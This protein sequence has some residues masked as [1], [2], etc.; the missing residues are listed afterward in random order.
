MKETELALLVDSLRGVAD[1]ATG[2]A[3]RRRLDSDPRLRSTLQGFAAVQ[4][5]L[6]AASPPDSALA[7]ARALGSQRRQ[8]PETTTRLRL[9]ALEP[10]LEGLAALKPAGSRDG[11][12]TL[13]NANSTETLLQA[14][15]EPFGPLSVELRVDRSSDSSRSVVVG[16]ILA[17][18]EDDAKPLEGV[19]VW[20]TVDD[21]ETKH[22]RTGEF[23]E[24][25]L[26]LP[27]SGAT[28]V[29][30]K[31]ADDLILCHGLAA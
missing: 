11:I 9:L 26:P 25:Y 18:R 1:E 30:L 20:A 4:A 5:G 27:S 3:F 17:G 22:S 2:Q 14:E 13:A 16:E 28:I 19:E 15:C 8:R 24:F 7:I 23:G 10:V 21:A 31:L 6:S 29:W 12:D